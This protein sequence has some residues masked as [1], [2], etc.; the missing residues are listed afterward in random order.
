MTLT[1]PTKGDE[2]PTNTIKMKLWEAEDLN[3]FPVKAEID[4]GHDH[5]FTVNYTN[6]SLAKPDPAL[7]KSPA[8]CPGGEAGGWQK[9]TPAKPAP[10]PAPKPADKPL[11]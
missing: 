9:V 7:F 6:V 8:V 11:H 5:K 4:A 10:K 2:H 3:G 1:S